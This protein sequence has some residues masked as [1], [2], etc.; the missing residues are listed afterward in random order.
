VPEQW[1]LKPKAQTRSQLTVLRKLVKQADEIIH[2]GDPD[3]ATCNNQ[4]LDIGVL[5]YIPCAIKKFP[6]RLLDYFNIEIS[7]TKTWSIIDILKRKKTLCLT[8]FDG[9]NLNKLFLPPNIV[10]F[11]Y[12]Q[13]YFNLSIISKR[14]L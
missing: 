12:H 5:L 9:C 1:Q 7:L 11:P 3:R 13:T 6:P 4:V 10:L 8:M 2:A 14:L